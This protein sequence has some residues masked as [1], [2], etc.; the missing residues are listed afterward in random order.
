MSVLT[1]HPCASRKRTCHCFLGHRVL[2]KTPTGKTDVHIWTGDCTPV[3]PASVHRHRRPPAVVA[4]PAARAL[5]GRLAAAA[6]TPTAGVAHDQ[7]AAAAEALPCL[8]KVWLVSSRISQ[9]SMIIRSMARFFRMFSVSLTSSCIILRG[10]ETAVRDRQPPPPERQECG[11][12]Q[13]WGGPAPGCP[14]ARHKAVE[15]ACRDCHPCLI[16]AF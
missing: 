2:D 3:T 1:L 5:T 16:V 15:Q 13:I 10:Q 12:L 4:A 9:P 8:T 11:V 7:V 6:A 14:R